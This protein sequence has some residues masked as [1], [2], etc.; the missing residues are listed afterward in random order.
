MA[1][2]LRWRPGGSLRLRP[3]NVVGLME[4]S[5]EHLLPACH[6]FLCQQVAGVFVY[7]RFRILLL[8]LF[9][10]RQSMAFVVCLKCFLCGD[11]IFISQT[12]FRGTLGLSKVLPRGLKKL[13]VR[14]R[15]S[16]QYVVGEFL[17]SG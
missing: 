10:T 13:R 7:I 8:E 16:T 3:L 15:V 12:T 4:D 5:A 9:N 14:P 6:T 2:Q 11:M 17:L 1:A